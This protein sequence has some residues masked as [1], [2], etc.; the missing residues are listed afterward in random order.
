ME[1]CILVQIILS[2][3]YR[4]TF[5][6]AVFHQ[7]T[8]QSEYDQMSVRKFYVSDTHPYNVYNLQ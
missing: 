1:C 5:Y 3:S 6:A 7:N 8:I 4:N 2:S